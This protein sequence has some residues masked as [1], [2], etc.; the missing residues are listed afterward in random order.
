MSIEEL[1]DNFNDGEFEEN[2]KPYFNDAL[3]FLK[4]AYKYG[5]VTQLDLNQLPYSDF[6][7][8]L[9]FL[10]QIDLIGN[11]DYEQVDEEFKNTILLYQLE[12][13]TEKTLN[14]VCDNLIT[15]V[16]FINGEYCLLVKDREE[17]AGL[18]EDKGRNTTSRDAAKAV[19]GE[20]MWDPFWD[21]TDNVYRDVID[22][23]DEANINALAHYIVKNI[24]GQ[25]FS[26]DDYDNQLFQE[27]SEEQGTEG[28]FQITSENVME[29]IKSEG[30]MKEMLK[31]DLNDLKGELYNI[32]NN[33]YNSS[34]ETEIYND[35]WS[36]LER[37]FHK[38]FVYDT[39]LIHG[40]KKTFEYLKI[41]DFYQL[42]YDF[43]SNNEGG[44]Y[45]D[46]S[47]EYFGTYVNVLGDLMDNSYGNDYLSVRISDY[48]DWDLT[49]KYI[50]EMFPDF[51]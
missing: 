18:F 51:I 34:Y 19:L 7:E 2:I 3:S 40:N 9:E 8:C 29:L 48:A 15:D 25:E 36:E 44:T 47:L 4:Y 38:E 35:V 42:V 13:D 1:V 39:E 20:D 45:S 50:N 26:L 24:G 6:K 16:Y 31:Q 10:D 28:F 46:S 33:A 17:L 37:Y 32:H 49:K 23:L 5:F 12:K 14:F 41:R 22:D 21:T 27:F 43:L 11:L 30:A